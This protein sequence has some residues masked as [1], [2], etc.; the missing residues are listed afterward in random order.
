VG[1]ATQGVVEP[2]VQ[3]A[4][5]ASAAG[6]YSGWVQFEREGYYFRD[7]QLGQGSADTG[8]AVPVFHMVVSLRGG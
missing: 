6:M 5:E 2:A 4:A 1:C 7:T 3:L 8:E